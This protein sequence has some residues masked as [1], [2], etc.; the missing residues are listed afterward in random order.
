MPR[1][2]ALLLLLVLLHPAAARA[3]DT[4][5]GPV[6]TEAPT[7]EPA[8][9]SDDVSRTTLYLIA[10]GVLVGV[11]AIGI[12]ISRDARRSLTPEDRE[13]IERQE[14]GEPPLGA[15]TTKEARARAKRQR[16]KVKAARRARRHN[17]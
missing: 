1:A 15:G 6:P 13:A 16:A 17:R 12:A 3:Q 8:P 4:P 7:V 10:G 14:R 2:I 5:F 9:G 11:V